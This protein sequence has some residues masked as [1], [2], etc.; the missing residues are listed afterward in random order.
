MWRH[1]RVYSDQLESTLNAVTAE[2]W[3]VVY[4]FLV[5]ERAWNAEK[6]TVEQGYKFDIV[7]ARAG[8]K[9]SEEVVN[10][11]QEAYDVVSAIKRSCCFIDM[12]SAIANKFLAL[13]S[14]LKR[15]EFIDKTCE[16]N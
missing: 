15:L 7:L 12:P 4:I 2:G 10:L 3:S 14:K 1:I 6:E 16:E 8:V 11:L 5:E 9:P 13:H